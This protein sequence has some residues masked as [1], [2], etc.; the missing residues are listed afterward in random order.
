MEDDKITLNSTA[1]AL[2]SSGIRKYFAINSGDCDCISLSVGEPDFPTPIEFIND[3]FQSAKM[4]YTHYTQNAG[5]EELRVEISKYL[6]NFIGVEYNPQSEIIVTNGCSEGIDIAL[7]CV[8]NACDE[9]IIPQPNFV[10]YEPLVRMAGAVPILT[11]CDKND[12]FNLKASQIENAITKKTKCVIL[13]YPNNPTGN[14]LDNGELK[15]IADIA[16][17]HD[18]IV[19]SD[20]TYCELIYG[21]RFHSISAIDGMRDRTII[22]S[23]FSKAFAM[24]GWRV[25]YVCAPKAICDVIR[26]LHQYCAMSACTTSQYVALSAL[27]NKNRQ[28][29]VDVMRNTYFERRQFLVENLNAM[30]IDCPLPDGTFYAFANVASVGIDGETF[31][32]QLLSREKVAVVPGVAFGDNAKEFVRISFA[33][34]LN[35]IQKALTRIDRFINTYPLDKDRQN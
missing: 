33:S 22:L 24:T 4:G 6:Q 14:I 7:R 5:L 25:G 8:C 2:K 3:G 28:R 17:A 21:K 23:G 30:G 11:N 13:S 34:S 20:E 1:T 18:L 16:K 27:K 15:K 19:I 12:N 26:K 31:A 9:V 29:Y 35:D 10:C 32:N